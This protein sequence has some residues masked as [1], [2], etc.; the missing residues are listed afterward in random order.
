M[1]RSHV[2]AGMYVTR[3]NDSLLSYRYAAGT[4]AQCR[5]NLM[6]Y[7]GYP[8]SNPAELGANANVG[9]L[10]IAEAAALG[11]GGCYLHDGPAGAPWLG[12]VRAA[13]NAFF[14]RNASLYRGMYPFGQV[15][16]AAF[17]LPSYFG[18]RTAL[19]GVDQALHAL[20]E[21]HVLADLIPERVFT[22]EWIRRYPALVVPFAPILSD[23]EVDTLIGYARAGGRLVLWG[24][25]VGSRD[26]LGRERGRE[27]LAKLRKAAAAWHREGPFPEDAPWL[28]EGA[29]CPPAAAPLVR[30]AAYVNDPARPT[31]LALHCVNYDVD[32]GLKHDHERCAGRAT[33]AVVRP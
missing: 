26:Q 18:D 14:A 24:D 6:G 20:A 8:K 9:A 16:I 31:R 17:T 28:S 2:I 33:Q 19:S 7:P 3:A 10:G 5:A 32:L 30:F 22:P 4:G 27:A 29:L 23:A 12:P 1:A 11:G 15:G 25:K 21:R 13:Y